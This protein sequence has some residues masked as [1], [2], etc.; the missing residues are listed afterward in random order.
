[1]KSL[2]KADHHSHGFVKAADHNDGLFRDIVTDEGS[3]VAQGTQ[4]LHTDDEKGTLMK[5]RLKCLHL[6]VSACLWK[7]EG[8]LKTHTHTHIPYPF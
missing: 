7:C 2:F 4:T 6:C 5:R 8:L 3:G 1:M